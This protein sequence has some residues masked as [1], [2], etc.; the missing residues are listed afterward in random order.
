METLQPTKAVHKKLLVRLPMLKTLYRWFQLVG[1]LPSESPSVPM[2]SEGGGPLGLSPREPL[3]TVSA[4]G[5]EYRW[6]EK[7]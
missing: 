3:P 2:V 4:G 5:S 7:V 6:F 1:L